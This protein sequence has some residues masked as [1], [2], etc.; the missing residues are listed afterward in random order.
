MSGLPRLMYT[1]P[2][3]PFIKSTSYEEHFTAGYGSVQ[4][5]TIVINAGEETKR[6][7]CFFLAVVRCN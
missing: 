7:G 1:T 6:E 4:N 2:G 3:T 5:W